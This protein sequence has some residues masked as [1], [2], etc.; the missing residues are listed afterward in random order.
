MGALNKLAA[1]GAEAID[2]NQRRVVTGVPVTQ[3]SAGVAI[4]GWRWLQT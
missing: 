1:G 3:S 2:V 4:D